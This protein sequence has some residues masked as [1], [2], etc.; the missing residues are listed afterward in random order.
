MGAGDTDAD[1]WEAHLAD[2]KA[3]RPFRDFR[4]IYAAAN[5]DRQYWSISGVPLFDDDGRFLGY[6]GTGRNLTE[7]YRAR[8]MAFEAQDLL[9]QA[10]EHFTSAVALFDSDDRL[11]LFNDSY[12]QMFGPGADSIVPGMTFRSEEHTSELQSLMRISYA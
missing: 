12:V 6:R 3:Y 2:L 4:Y 10:I 9:L 1:K 5:G 11:L 8:R 7:E